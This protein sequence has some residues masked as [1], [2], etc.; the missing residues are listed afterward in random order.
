MSYDKYDWGED[1]AYLA[2]KSEWTHEPRDADFCGR[3]S[4]LKAA[5]KEALKNAWGRTPFVGQRSTDRWWKHCSG[6]GWV[7]LSHGQLKDIRD[8]KRSDL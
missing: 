1:E 7:E 5:Q 6:D 4:T 3:F 2:Y 8:P